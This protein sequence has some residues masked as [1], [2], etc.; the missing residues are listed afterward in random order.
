[1]AQYVTY[2]RK[3]VSA[4]DSGV[5]LEMHESVMPVS[6]GENTVNVSMYWRSLEL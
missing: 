6:V 3:N 2:R 5:T 4:E 1:M